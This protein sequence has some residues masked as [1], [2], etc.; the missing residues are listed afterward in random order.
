MTFI[1]FVPDWTANL[2]ESLAA[3]PDSVASLKKILRDVDVKDGQQGITACYGPGPR[4][5]NGTFIA[6]TPSAGSGGNEI[7]PFEYD[8]TCK[9]SGDSLDC[10]VGERQTWREIQNADGTTCYW[11]GWRNDAKPTP[12]DLVR[13]KTIDGHKCLLADG[14]EWLVPVV[15]PFRGRLPLAFRMSA[16]GELFAEVR[17][18]FKKLMQDSEDIRREAFETNTIVRGKM[19]LYVAALLNVNYR[20]GPHEIADDCLG[21]VTT[22]NYVEPFRISIGERD[23]AIDAE[24][25][26]N[27]ASVQADT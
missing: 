2:V 9:Q 8:A 24:L 4:G 18:D 6:A 17:S 22:E 10:L 25:K 14:N 27:T 5:R 7:A 16:K 11:F 3:L 20:V 26:K 12:A 21:L 1:Y 23:A 13:N 15:G 19:W